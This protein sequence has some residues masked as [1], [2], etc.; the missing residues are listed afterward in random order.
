MAQRVLTTLLDD[1]DGSEASETVAFSL[2]GVELEIDLSAGNAESLRAVFDPYIV[3][4]RRVSG[5]LKRGTRRVNARSDTPTARPDAGTPDVG[6]RD[7][8]GYRRTTL[9]P[10][11]EIIR[12]WARENGHTVSDYGRIRQSLVDAFVASEEG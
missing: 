1:T 9:A 5:R 12:R 8:A 3:C 6:K 11:P 7:T 4:S 10:S 2:D